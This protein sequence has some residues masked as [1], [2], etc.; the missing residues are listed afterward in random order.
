MKEQ[1][2]I[3]LDNYEAYFLDYH[4]G[5][6]S[7]DLIKELMDFITLH[8]VLREEFE[9][10]EPI[11]LKAAEGVTYHEKD[12]LK[13]QLAGIN[14]TNFDKYAVEYV[15]GTLP[16][17]LQNEL[18][19]FI[20]QNPLYQKELELY[21]KTKLAP[22]TSIVFE[23]KF[24][25]KRKYKSPAAWYYWSAAA[26]VAVII[27]A[28]FLLDRSVK[29]NG[30]TI[31]KHD[32]VKDTNEVANHI[33]KSVDSTVVIPKNIPNTPANNVASKNVVVK[34]I[35]QQK[36]DKK[37]IVAPVNT[38]RDSST[39]VVNKGIQENDVVPVKKE[40]LVPNHPGNDS[41]VISL[42]NL[43]DTL[44]RAPLIKKDL[45]NI[46]PQQ[47][48]TSIRIPKRKK[49]GKLLIMLAR[50]TCKGLH[51]ITGQHIE[52]ET[53]YNSDTTYVV[54]YQLD[55]GNKKIGFPVKE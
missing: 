26:S 23:E 54:A 4:E 9:S 22:D 5:S 53:H 24:S 2:N 52:L 11:A 10:Y 37:E 39:I 50:L 18:K 41:L 31:A 25:L 38:I 29:P 13:K 49:R 40:I 43:R 19:A 21:A 44:Q 8:P 16:V 27:G 28:Y 12:T 3:N 45:T 35:A 14:A 30:N 15:E 1:M 32:Q 36:Q 33:A 51:N 6:L 48:I 34:N 42:H 47:Q 20:T 7:P 55:L 17:A 46:V